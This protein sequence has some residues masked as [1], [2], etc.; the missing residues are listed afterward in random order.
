MIGRKIFI[1]FLAALLFLVGIVGNSNIAIAAE[2][3]EKNSEG[4]SLISDLLTIFPEDQI[5]KAEAK[6][7]E[8]KFSKYQPSQYNLEIFTE[9]TSFYELDTKLSNQVYIL[10]NE[11]NNFIW[12]ALLSWNFTVILIVENAFS[13][14][15]VDQFADAVEE[16]VQQLAGF[17][18]SGYGSTG[19]MGNF[20]TLMIIIAGAWIAYKGLIKKKT[21][22]A[23]GGM[24]SS[25]LVLMLGLVFFAN[26]GGVMQYLNEISSGLSQ[27][28]MGVGIEFQEN[29]EEG[30]VN[31]PADVSSLVVSDKLYNMM[32]YEPYLM[33]QYAK[34]SSD[35]E[36]T[37]G[38]IQK[39]LAFKPGSTARQNMVKEEVKKF[40]NPMVT[41]EGVFQRL[42]LLILLCVSH[43][44]LGLLFLFIAGAM[45]VYQFLFL[46]IALFAPFA[47]LMALN[48]A[49]S[50]V[51]VNWFKKFVGYQ[52]IKLIIGVFFSMLLT[53][54][55]FLYTMSPP[56]KVGYIWT[57]AIQLIL[58]I[59]VIWKREELFSIM[60]APMGKGDSF[61]GEFNIQMPIDYMTKYTQSLA[62]KAKKIK[63][64]R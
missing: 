36:L 37:Q 30:E 14:N 61:K 35:P 18:G 1:L 31:Y 41:T 22:E 50:S 12:Q 55:Q 3:Q 32:V 38:R 11:F 21:T 45:I 27:E 44:I 9:E 2:E 40:N 46:L 34:T 15:V 62:S 53:I 59:G 26:A 43:F 13:L 57:I 52:L 42:T 58:V 5:E 10:I 6:G 29:L 17:S 4:Y 39:I 56:D 47:F 19:L 8:V 20:L 23:L 54:S 16:A 60:K 51:A 48:P 33:L 28:L 64:R 49:W 24:L 7:Y 63:L 25:V